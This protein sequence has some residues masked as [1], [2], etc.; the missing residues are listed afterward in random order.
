MK[1]YTRILEFFVINPKQKFYNF[2]ISNQGRAAETYKN[3][4]ILCHLKSSK[5]SRSIFLTETFFTTKTYSNRKKISYINTKKS[6]TLQ[7]SLFGLL[8][9]LAALF[10]CFLP[11]PAP[12]RFNLSHKNQQKD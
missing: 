3:L 10:V 5:G 9:S 11:I 12:L 8:R 7:L 6:L 1:P 2:S 4:R